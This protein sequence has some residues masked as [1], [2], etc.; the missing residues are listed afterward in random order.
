MGGAVFLF[1]PESTTRKIGGVKRSFEYAVESTASPERLIQVL[2]DFTERRPD[3]WPALSRRHYEVLDTGEKTA[4]VREGTSLG[5]AVERYDWSEPGVVR[6]I[7]MES[8]FARPGTEW[9][10]RVTPRDGGSHIQA[11]LERDYKGPLGLLTYSVIAAS[12]GGKLLAKYLRRTLDIIER[13]EELPNRS[14]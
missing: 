14:R 3:Y 12:G 9:A 1:A 11:R 10:M 4:L 5:W 8:N 6:S 2:T 13:E 7:C